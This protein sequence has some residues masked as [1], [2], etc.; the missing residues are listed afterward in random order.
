[1]FS[2]TIPSK[3]QAYMAA[4]KPILM[5]VDGDAADLVRDAGCGVVSESDNPQ[6]LANAI[7]ALMDVSVQGHKSMAENGLEY[8]H[9][10][11]SLRVGVERFGEH[12]K[13]LSK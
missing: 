2:I 4:G 13:R 11:L 1:M 10:E 6:A 12:F 8:Y 5:A 3:T 9:Q 7:L